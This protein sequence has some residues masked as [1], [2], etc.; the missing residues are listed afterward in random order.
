MVLPR[1]PGGAAGP[2]APPRGCRRQRERKWMRRAWGSRKTPR[3]QEAG[4]CVSGDGAGRARTPRRRPGVAR[5]GVGG[6]GRPWP[7]GNGSVCY[8]V[9]LLVFR[10]LVVLVFSEGTERNAGLFRLGPRYLFASNGKPGPSSR[11][12]QN[13][14]HTRRRRKSTPPLSLL[15]STSLDYLHHCKNGDA[16]VKKRRPRS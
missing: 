11:R 10:F 2:A 12:R 15:E 3:A 9:F 4:T 8:C 7:F 16:R 1:A 5:R 6:G 13:G 14:S